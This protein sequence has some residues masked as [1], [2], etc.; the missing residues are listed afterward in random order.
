MSIA[1]STLVGQRIGEGRPDVAAKSAVISGYML[2]FGLIV[3]LPDLLTKAL[4][5]A[6]PADAVPSE[7][8]NLVVVLLRFVALY[9]FFD[10]MAIIFGSRGAGGGDT[11]FSMLFTLVSSMSLVLPTFVTQLNYRNDPNLIWWSW[12]FCWCTSSL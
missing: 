8:H 9:S 7:I 3:L 5:L 10:A 2:M 1:V 6:N 4:R 11:V 12:V